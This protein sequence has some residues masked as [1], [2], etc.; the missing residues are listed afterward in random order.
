MR[1]FQTAAGIRAARKVWRI[2]AIARGGLFK[3]DKIFVHGMPACLILTS[4]SSA[5]RQFQYAVNLRSYSLSISLS[6]ILTISGSPA[7]SRRIRRFLDWE[8]CLALP[9]QINERVRK[10]PTGFGN[11][12]VKY[13]RDHAPLLFT[14]PPFR[15]SMPRSEYPVL[16]YSGGLLYS[17]DL[18]FF[19]FAHE[20]GA[21]SDLGLLHH[22]PCRFD[23]LHIDFS[24]AGNGGTRSLE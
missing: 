19:F 18:L 11:D 10:F 24:W 4:W 21:T 17:S 12:T 2:R 20:H 6:T 15:A 9:L 5:A 23:S 3:K 13:C 14:P 22:L 1:R 7:S 8:S 16:V